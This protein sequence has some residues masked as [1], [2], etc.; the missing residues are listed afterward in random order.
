MNIRVPIFLSIITAILIFF[1]GKKNQ[2]VY[3]YILPESEETEQS[4]GKERLQYEFDILKNPLTGTIPY[5]IRRQELEATRNIPSRN[6]PATR[7][8]NLNTY[9]ACGP[10]AEGGRTRALVPDIRYNGTTNR[11]L[12]AGGVNGGLYR[13]ADG[14]TT[15]NWVHP[16]NEIHAVTAIAQDPRPG[17]QDTWYAG[18]GEFSGASATINTAFISSMGIFKSIDNGISWT[19]TDPAIRNNDAALTPLTPGTYEAFD[20][21]LDLVHRIAVHPVTG[22]VFIACHRRIL[23]STNGG[24]SFDV[25]LGGATGATNATGQTEIVIRPDGSKIYAGFCG[26]NPDASLVGVWESSNGNADIQGLPNT[27]WTRIAGSAAGSPAGWNA[28]GNW[29][30]IVMG[31]APSSQNILYVLFEH[32]DGVTAKLFRGDLNSSTWTERTAGLNALQNTTAT[33]FATQG[34]YDLG[35]AVKPNDANTVFAV[36]TNL[37]RSTDGFATIP[38]SYFAGGYGSTSYTG[39][40]H[41]DF[42]YAVFNPSNPNEL[43][44]SNDGGIQKTTN[45][46]ASS[47]TWT[48]LNNSYQT[49]QYYHTAIDPTMNANNFA[50]GCQDNSTTFRDATGLL[51]FLGTTNGVDDHWKLIGG[52]GAAVGITSKDPGNSNRQFLFAS[53]QQGNIYR[54]KLFNDGGGGSLFTSIKPTGAGSGQFVTYFHLDNDNTN[55]LYYTNDNSLY[56]ST[57]SNTVVSGGW[58]NMTG[59]SGTITSPNRIM[60]LATTRGVYTANSNLFIGTSNGAIFR[61][62]DPANTIATTTPTMILSS[63]SGLTTTGSTV[64]DISVNPRNQDSLLAVVSNYGVNSIFF[65]SNATAAAPSWTVCEGNLALPSIQSCEIVLKN[66][67]VE[68]YVGTS[69][70][71]FSTTSLNGAG[72]AWVREGSGMMKFAVIRSLSYRWNDNTMVIGTHGNGMF[73]TFIGDAVAIATGVNNITRNDPGLIRKIYPTVTPNLIQYQT[74]NLIGIHKLEIRLT[75]ITG[76]LLFRKETGYTDGTL[77]MGRFASGEY[78]VTFTNTEKNQLFVQKIIKQ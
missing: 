18:G 77:D 1:S 75:D 17:F 62:T 24:T 56:R 5:N 37:Y 25:V 64:L 16:E 60:S 50:G 61:L 54:L 30:R 47:I 70:G 59:V 66:S 21:P 33:N 40:S 45:C 8:T 78:I 11:V 7:T 4:A 74:G 27:N 12:L 57:N 34:G 9:I 55:N 76:R 10:T 58:T 32:S 20:H 52:D 35:I 19:R 15:W 69:V 13:S 51:S 63:L 72:T 3:T 2:P 46:T 28:P 39:F 68:F 65:T 44:V 42:H 26:T 23:R 49:H 31:V 41:P 29:G 38:N 43:F 53:T 6:D 67:G 48:D 73:Y 22:H 36:G 14:G 71:L